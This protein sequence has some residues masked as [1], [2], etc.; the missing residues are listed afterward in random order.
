LRLGFCFLRLRLQNSYP[1]DSLDVSSAPLVYSAN[2]K[3]T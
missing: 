3:P 2:Y 1:H